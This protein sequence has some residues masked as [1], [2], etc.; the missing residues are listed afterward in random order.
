M[1]PT[2]STRTSAFIMAAAAL[3]FSVT[4]C[5]HKGP[6]SKDSA[7]SA[8]NAK[9]STTD[10]AN[11][12]M[13]NKTDSASK[14]EKSGFKDDA[15]FVADAADGGAYEIAAAQVALKN[16]SDKR[17]KEFASMMIRDHTKWG[18]SIKAYAKSKNITLPDS[19][20][21]DKKDKVNKL[22]QKGS[23]KFD[24]K[25]MDN[26][27]KDHKDDLDAF[28]DA[29]KNTKDAALKTR[30]DKIIPGIQHHLMMATTLDSII[31]KE[32]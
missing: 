21:N 20:S 16:S 29:D 12:S 6:D 3:S 17:V 4:A 24:V 11:R 1:K 10:S 7:D 32:K 28:N 13:S 25:Y 9:A 14:S 15:H 18:S 30:L 5:N 26:M 23:D 2:K 22:A 8:N 19:L 31:D 27:K